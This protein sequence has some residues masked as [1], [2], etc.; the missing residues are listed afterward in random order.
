MQNLINKMFGF[1]PKGAE[2]ET[3]DDAL[4]FVYLEGQPALSPSGEGLQG[5]LVDESRGEFLRC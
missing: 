1:F 3:T 4:D 5:T 2:F